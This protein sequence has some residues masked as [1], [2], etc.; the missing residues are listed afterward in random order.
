[1]K[2]SIASNA[3][4]RNKPL[5]KIVITGGLG[6]IGSRVYSH[7]SRMTETGE[8]AI[9]D[10]MTYAADVRRI[11]GGPGIYGLP[12]IHGDIR[13]AKDVE[14]ALEDCDAVVHLAAETHIPRS[15]ADPELFFDVNVAGTETLLKIARQQGVKHFV[16]VSSSAVYGSVNGPVSETA[17]M[18]PTTPYAMSKALAEEAV[19]QAA[20]EGLNATI[21]R[22]SNTVGVGQHPE[23]LFPR[24]VMRALKGQRLTIEGDGRQVRSFLP[25]GDLAK[26]IG[27]VLSRPAPDP[28]AVYNISGE[29]LL[30]VRDVAAKVFEVTGMKTGL[31]FVRDREWNDRTS[32]ISDAEI[33]GLG[34]R[35][36]GSVRDE[37]AAICDTFRARAQSVPQHLQ[38][39]M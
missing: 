35:Q 6:F 31:H 14:T 28:L 4:K 19:M 32:L 36:T 21:L 17:P 38:V 2:R 8:T 33:R 12:L 37:L 3:P 30:S 15:I 29:E 5:R 27:L 1:M 25:V 22:P 13:S 11:E 7:V 23:K 18:R 16:H 39:K 34:Y 10:R 26:A 9:L 20:D 24:F